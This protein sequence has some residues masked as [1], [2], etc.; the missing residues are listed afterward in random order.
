MRATLVCNAGD[1]DTANE[2]YLN[3]FHHGGHHQVEGW[4]NEGALSGLALVALCQ[5]LAQTRGAIVEIGVHHGRLF[6]AMA[7][8]RHAGEQAVAYDVFEDQWLNVDNS[9]LGSQAAL[10]ANIDKHIGSM[11]EVVVVKKDSLTLS[12]QD[13]LRDT[14]GQNVRLFSVDGGH[15]CAHAL[16]DLHL[17][18]EVL[19]P[20]GVVIVDDFFHP[21]WPGVTEASL[22]YLNGG[23]CPLAPFGYGNNKLY[24]TRK[25]DVEGFTGFRERLARLYATH[26][27]TEIAGF[28][29]VSMPLP[30]PT[31]ALSDYTHIT[32]PAGQPIHFGKDGDS[33]FF[34]GKGWSQV[35]PGGC[36]TDGFSAELMMCVD[37]PPGA[38]VLLEVWG[39]AFLTEDHPSQTVAVLANGRRIAQLRYNLDDGA[40]TTLRA[41]VIPDEVVS[42]NDMLCVEFQFHH[43]CSPQSLGVSRDSR[44]LGLLV[45][46]VRVQPHHAKEKR[47]A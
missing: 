7:L 22:L 17:A 45:K 46:A 4:L 6:I 12:A 36:W 30:G 43:A 5:E 8:V 28:P 42:Q 23:D 24:L 33:R 47:S 9:G 32:A 29:C 2:R 1:M 15:T 13:I 39:K 35:E 34:V 41:V 11:D 26:K 21:D 16:N 37:R 3:Y 27:A 19:A 40:I 18:G 20:G 44:T 25:E 10:L 14:G 31:Q 38:D